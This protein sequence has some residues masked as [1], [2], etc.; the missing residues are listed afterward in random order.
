[1]DTA[2]CQQFESSIG[3]GIGTVRDAVRH[4]LKSNSAQYIYS[5][6]GDDTYKAES[7]RCRYLVELKETGDDA[8]SV[9][10]TCKSEE[11][12]ETIERYKEEF[13]DILDLYI[14]K[15]DD[16]DERLNAIAGYIDER[17]RK[18]MDVGISCI[19]MLFWLII[20]AILIFCMM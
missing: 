15:D 2:N 10:I 11:D 3:S 1:M 6:I 12:M 16:E 14:D 13:L 7:I 9:R 5:E 20:Q 4:A 18:M 8:T 17:Y 19:V